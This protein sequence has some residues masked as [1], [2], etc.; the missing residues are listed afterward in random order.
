MDRGRPGPAGRA[1]R[2]GA[3]ARAGDPPAAVG[4]SKMAATMKKAVSARGAGR[5]A[6]R[7]GPR[8]GGRGREVPPAPEVT[9]RRSGGT[10]ARGRAAAGPGRRPGRG[11]RCTAGERHP[12]RPVAALTQRRRR[13]A[14][15]ADAIC[16]RRSLIVRVCRLQCD[17]S[18][19]FFSPSDQLNFHWTFMTA[20]TPATCA[21]DLRVGGKENWEVESNS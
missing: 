2:R 10:E 19:H 5:G 11:P 15:P 9:P 21:K 6:G 20:K 13:P 14:Q 16:R 3:G 7:G 4:Q 1:R 12:E 8:R 18:S 17:T